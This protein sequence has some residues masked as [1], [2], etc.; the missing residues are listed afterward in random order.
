MPIPK[1]YHCGACFY[2]KPHKK[3]SEDGR[4]YYNQ[5]SIEVVTMHFC[6]TWTCSRC[7]VK[8][9]SHTNHET[10][11]PVAFEGHIM[12]E[13]PWTGAER[14]SGADRRRGHDRRIGDDRR[15]VQTEP[16]A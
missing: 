1:W 14:R 8:G 11:T 12:R 6:S 15:K 10:C 2:Y 3:G 5:L 4:C 16:P 13:R 9:I 7:F